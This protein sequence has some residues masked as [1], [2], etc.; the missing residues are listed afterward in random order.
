M[1]ASCGL[2]GSSVHVVNPNQFAF[3]YYDT[4]KT[5]DESTIYEQGRH[6]LGVGHSFI[7]FPSNEIKID[8]EEMSLRTQDGL[9]VQ[10]DIVFW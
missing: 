3:N 10:A 1:V 9:S 2:L 5:V 8:V 4:Y 6:F 7:S